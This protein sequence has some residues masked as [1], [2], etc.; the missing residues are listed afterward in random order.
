[1]PAILG[2]PHPEFLIPTSTY[3][4]SEVVMVCRISPTFTMTDEGRLEPDV[5]LDTSTCGYRAWSGHLILQNEAVKEAF[6]ATL[7]M[8]VEDVI[9]NGPVVP[10]HAGFVG[11]V[12]TPP[13][14]GFNLATFSLWNPLPHHYVWIRRADGPLMTNA[15][16]R[17][18]RSSPFIQ[19]TQPNYVQRW[20]T[21]FGSH[22]D[23]DWDRHLPGSQF[24][25]H[26]FISVLNPPGGPLED[27]EDEEE[28]TGTGEGGDN[29]L[30]VES[31]HSETE[32]GAVLEE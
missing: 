25:G 23:M 21:L 30:L 17:I 3:P 1:M 18:Y 26:S 5:T 28:I 31:F 6:N 14:E 8:A 20:W 10:G 32:S 15:E 19:A 13:V 7:V 27:T 9:N 16:R 22:I 2:D 12:S 24:V 29:E 4:E 11:M